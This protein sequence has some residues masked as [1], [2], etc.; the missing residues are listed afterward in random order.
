MQR[1]SV[2]LF[3]ISRHHVAQLIAAMATLLVVHASASPTKQQSTEADTRYPVRV[4]LREVKNRI[5]EGT[6]RQHKLYVDQPKAFGADDTAPTPPETLAFALGSCVISTARLLAMQRALVV[7]NISA[8]VEGELDFARALGVQ[9]KAR[10]GFGRL[11]INVTLDADMSEAD[12]TRF[13]RDVGSRCP[14]CDNLTNVTP[15][16]IRMVAP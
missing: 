5:V 16:S 3:W 13:L 8:T 11:A 15:V 7:H 6:V 1:P 10:A 9:T 14:L 12:K 2:I 4:A